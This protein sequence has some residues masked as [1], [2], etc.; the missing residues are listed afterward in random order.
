MALTLAEINDPAEQLAFITRA[1]QRQRAESA[2]LS[3]ARKTHKPHAMAV[4]ASAAPVP[5]PVARPKAVKQALTL[6]DLTDGERRRI[7]LAFHE[8]GH[9]VAGVLL[10]GR[11]RSA[12]VVDT[13]ALG[14]QGKTMYDDLSPGR[15]PEV[16]Y[17]G[18]WSEA[19]WA[20][21][22]TPGMAELFRVWETSG[23]GDDKMLCAAGGMRSDGRGVVP[24]LE[25][26]WPS[27]V[28]VAQKLLRDGE[29]RHEDVCAALKIPSRD[30][31]HHLALIRSGCAPGGFTVTQAAL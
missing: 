9:A 27:V 26:C 20:A 3:V 25:R 8:S 24:L 29:V 7:E 5:A 13:G 17:A 6:A 1:V 30:N 16:A 15:Y 31:G 19:R 22:R 18:P 10:D 28:K 2:R 14:L 21:G 12:F 23:R 4:T 11:I